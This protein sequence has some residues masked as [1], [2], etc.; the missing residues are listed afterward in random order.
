MTIKP[1]SRALAQALLDHHRARVT[2][3]PPRGKPATAQYLVRYGDLCAKAGVPHLTRVVGPFLREIA[4]WCKAAGYP[5]LNALAVN[6]TGMPGE[7]YDGAGGYV[8]N[9]WPKDVEACILFT[10]YPARLP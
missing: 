7:G 10:G 9:E 6:Q 2:E 8:M 1:E 3:L 4:E 5:P